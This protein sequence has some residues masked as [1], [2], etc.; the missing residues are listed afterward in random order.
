MTTELPINELRRLSPAQLVALFESLEAPPIE[1]MNGEYRAQLLTQPHLP[2]TVMGHA[3]VSNP[4]NYWLSKAFRPV[5][6]ETGRGYNTFRR[7]G[8]VVQQYPMTTLIAP[9]RYDGKPAYTLIYRAFRSLCGEINMVDEIR[10]LGPGIY[11]GIGTCGVTD[12]QRRLPR[13]FLL[14]GPTHDY[15]GDIG[16]ARAGFTPGKKEIPRGN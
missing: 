13:P 16:K 12:S 14:Q 1:E 4:L 11:L 9:S 8:S 6:A 3:A 5:D 10:R 15:R 7:L 2:A